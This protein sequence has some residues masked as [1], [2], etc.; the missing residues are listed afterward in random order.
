MT[1]ET[2]LADLIPLW[3][4]HTSPELVEDLESGFI[5][6]KPKLALELKRRLAGRLGCH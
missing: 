5:A 1:R 3:P 2:A 6:R 4:D